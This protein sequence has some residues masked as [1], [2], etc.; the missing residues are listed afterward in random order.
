[1]VSLVISKHT[2]CR[3]GPFRGQIV[4][5]F[6]RSKSDAPDK[7]LAFLRQFTTVDAYPARAVTIPSWSNIANF[8]FPQYWNAP[9]ENTNPNITNKVFA[10]KPNR[11]TKIVIVTESILTTHEETYNS[12]LEED[13]EE[14]EPRF[15]Q[16]LVEPSEYNSNNGARKVFDELSDWS[17]DVI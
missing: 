14:F 16:Y 2:T 15:P 7:H 4:Y 12:V 5:S 8:P 1:M 13:K 3:L 9:S 11:G 6:S 10:K 17:E